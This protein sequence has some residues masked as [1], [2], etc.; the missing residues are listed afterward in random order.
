VTD[1]PLPSWRP[2]PTR[3]AL[4]QLVDR[5]QDLPPEHR[6]AVFDNDGTLWCEKPAYIQLSFFLAELA[7]AIEADAALADRVEYAALLGG[8]QATIDQL[9]LPRIALALAELFDGWAPDRFADHAATFVRTGTH[10][11]LH[12]PFAEVVYQPMLELLGLLREAGFATFIV[13]GGGTEFVRAVSQELYGVPPEGVVGTLIGYDATREDGTPVV[14]RTASIHGDA[15]EGMAKVLHIQQHLG[16]PPLFAAGNTA[17]D[18]EMLEWAAGRPGGMGLL[19]H[20]DDADREFA[21]PGEAGTFTAGEAIVDT[22]RSVGWT[23]ASMR[24]DWARIFP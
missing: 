22:A 16:R 12:C 23:V 6:T 15:N 5:A 8:D 17:G 10:P 9:G 24:D 13:S 2:G 20:H 3:D 1:E 21:Y 7:S 18:R 19:I 4:L 11:T 14:R